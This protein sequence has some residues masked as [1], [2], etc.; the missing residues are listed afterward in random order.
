MRTLSILIFP[1]LLLAASAVAQNRSFRS[2]PLAGK[3][4]N[5][6]VAGPK[7]EDGPKYARAMKVYRKLVAARGDFRYPVP[8][9]AMRREENRVAGM[10]YDQLEIILEEKAFDVCASYGESADA[11]IAFLLGHELT[12]YYEK[13][14]WR[15]GFVADFK[16]L[17]IGLKLDSLVDDAA[18]ETEADYGGGFLAY[19]AGYGLFDQGAD[20]IAKL[21]KAY[22]LKDTLQG[23]P[24]LADRQALSRRTAEKLEDLVD[25]F[26]L[27]NL[28][29]ATGRY[30]EANEYYRYVL[31]EY[32]SREIYNNVGVTAMLAAM[33]F[34]K[35][36][37]LKFHYPVELDLESSAS[38]GSGMAEASTR[39]LREALLHFDAAISLDPGY[40]PAYL[41]QACAYALLGDTARAR[42]YGGV[43]A[44]AA[45]HPDYSK[46]A[47]DVDVLLGILEAK[48]GHSEKAAQLFKSAAA[49]GS[50]LAAANLRIL[51]NEKSET[52]PPAFSGLHQPEKIDGEALA[53]IREENKFN[54]VQFVAFGKRLVL[55]RN[56]TPLPASSLFVSANDDKLAY[57]HITG[58][59]Y[60]GRTARKIGLGDDRAA[61]VKA[62]REPARSLESTR[63]Q[64]LVYDD[65][66]FILGPDG[67]LARWVNFLD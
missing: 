35:E 24:T 22:R 19:S 25:V 29:T 27:A 43:E 60:K 12:H 31:M 10:D 26:D 13:H 51:N 28:L 50:A 56:A 3:P 64:I 4:G 30:A 34:F 49:R 61:I 33:E 37:E 38:K 23:Y 6:W 7:L 52:A 41:N 9:F 63:G 47:L 32:Q 21:Y 11:A 17:S 66:I 65:I 5:S 1:V 8:A 55:Y 48:G 62:Y 20:M 18:N 40:A 16:D 59:G 2:L 53:S 42:F 44:R 45:A 39:L 58:T 14:G 46:T 67:R 15:R 57:F 36:G 54:P